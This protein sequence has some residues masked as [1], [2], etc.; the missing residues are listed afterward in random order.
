MNTSPINITA[1]KCRLIYD[2]HWHGRNRAKEL[3][4]SPHAAAIAEK[5]K[6]CGKQDSQQHALCEC[7]DHTSVKLRETILTR[8]TQH[9]HNYDSAKRTHQMIG[10]SVLSLLQETTEPGRI[11]IGNF[12]QEQVN[13]L[14]TAIS[15]HQLSQFSQPQLDSIFLDISRIL[16][17]GAL[18]INHRKQLAER[19]GQKETKTQKKLTAATRKKGRGRPKKT[20]SADPNSLPSMT[21]KKRQ[22]TT[23]ETN[24]QLSNES[25][26]IPKRLKLD[27]FDAKEPADSLNFLNDTPTIKRGPGRPKKHTET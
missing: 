5:C 13:H 27:K 4:L 1:S 16:T 23:I 10:R 3:A 25:E 26:P 20:P 14:M 11:W 22:Q 21:T 19:Y 17:E 8:L 9:I 18:S 24:T 7:T 2:K 15:A 6:L 12:S